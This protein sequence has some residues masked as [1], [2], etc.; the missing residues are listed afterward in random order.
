[1]RMGSS[2][3]VI[4]S[5]VLVEPAKDIPGIWMAYCLDFDVISQGD[6][7]KDAIDCIAEAV[8]M[9]VMDDLD[10]G[11]DPFARQRAP[12]IFWDRLVRVLEHGEEIKI[13]EVERPSMLALQITLVFKRVSRDHRDS[14]D[15]MLNR[16]EPTGYIDQFVTA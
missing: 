5:W 13:S 15:M 3:L 14:V 16:P 1:M 9:A 10:E 2:Q 6:S 11:R 7:P 4:T 12:E 8:Q